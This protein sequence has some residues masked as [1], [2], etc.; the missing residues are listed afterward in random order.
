VW[1]VELRG[2]RPWTV[3]D[4][5]AANRFTV[6]GLTRTWVEYGQFELAPK[7]PKFDF[8]VD[9]ECVQV[10]SASSLG[11]AGS[12]FLA[13][14]ALIDGIVHAGKLPDDNG[15]WVK[16]LRFHAPVRG[17]TDLVRLAFTP[18]A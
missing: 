6:A 12:M 10:S 11:D 18:A 14:K 4:A 1:V 3:N 8:P 13:V 7:L 9:I 15:K 16:S 5:L 2:Q 17:K